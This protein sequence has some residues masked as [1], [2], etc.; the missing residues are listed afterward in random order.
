MLSDIRTKIRALIGDISSCECEVFTYEGSNIFTLCADNV[1]SIT[2]V[3]VNGNELASGETYTYD[4]TCNKLTIDATLTTNDIIEVKFCGTKYSDAELNSYVEASLVYIS[5]HDDC[6][7]E[8]FELD[9][10][11]IF[12]TPTNKEE[13]LIALIA[14]IMI[15]PDYTV[16]KLGDLRVQYPGNMTK[17]ERI[18]EFITRFRRGI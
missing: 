16:Y 11:E 3:T 10:E 14:S 6:S 12:P 8:D 5:I 2:S 4:A 17:E 18:I 15:K 7:D 1:T 13:D 9:D